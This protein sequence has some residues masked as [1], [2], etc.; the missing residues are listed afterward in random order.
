MDDLD[1]IV[2]ANE[3]L[4]SESEVE[5][6]AEA[7]GLDDQLAKG[8]D[9]FTFD[10]ILTPDLAAAVELIT[11]PYPVEGLSG[12]VILLNGYSG[13]NKIKTR[14]YSDETS[15]VHPNSYV[16]GIGVTGVSKT[17]ILDV[18]IRDPVKPLQ[19]EA[20]EDWSRECDQWEVSCREQKLKKA[21]RPPKPKPLLL[22]HNNITEAALVLW[23]E[24]HANKGVGTHLTCDELSGY[25]QSLVHDAKRG[26]GTAEGQM[27]SLF[28]G[29]AHTEI[30]VG[31]DGG[32]ELRCF[33]DSLVSIYGGI[34]PDKLKELMGS[35]DV[36]GKFARFLFVR[37][38]NQPLKLRKQKWTPEEVQALDDA[39]Q[40][41]KD[42]AR[43]IYCLPPRAYWFSQ[44]AKEWFI[45]WFDKHQ[46]R[47]L[48][49]ATPQV[50]A[51]M[52]NKASAQ[53]RRVAGM[54]HIVRVAGG[55][56]QPDDPISLD[57]VKLAGAMVD[58]LFAETEQFHHG[59]QSASTL[60][61]RHI[62]Q[63]ALNAGKAISRQDARDKTSTKKER[64]QITAAD[65]KQWV[66]K[67]S[68]L[69][70]GT[71]TTTSRGAPLYEATRPMSV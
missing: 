10:R 50:I 14:I 32:G 70:Y 66:N 11:E 31:V 71:V 46:R 23:L 65:F 6:A 55:V 36:T 61:M 4:F 60:M 42:Y 33:Q 58:Q 12:S 62:H 54:L 67:L 8:R 49:P 20:F 59:S 9:Q 41:L 35:K 7:L 69:D 68:Q 15:S 21:D 44:P 30:R 56:A 39:R 51:A 5:S 63:V 53:I 64:D 27:L 38:L 22:Q 19:I 16:A 18:L 3:Q 2:D 45:D 17:P 28:D 26:R 52:L 24:H 13:L 29:G 25:L 1:A 40:V 48:L 37:L 43:K 47:G 57:L 34:Q